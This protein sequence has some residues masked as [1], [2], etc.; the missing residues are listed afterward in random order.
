[1]DFLVVLMR[2]IKIFENLPQLIEFLEELWNSPDVPEGEVTTMAAYETVADK[3]AEKY[4]DTCKS[5][6]D[7]V[8]EEC[9]T[10]QTAETADAEAAVET[11]AVTAQ[12]RRWLELIQ[13]LV[14]NRDSIKDIIDW[15]QK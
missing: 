10:E 5:Y 11:E 3:M 8:D 4:E 2:L 13:W 9:D 6:C 1:M 15:F 7:C 14:E 12:R